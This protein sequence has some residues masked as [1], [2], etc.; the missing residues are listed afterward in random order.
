[1][2][3]WDLGMVSVDDI[4]NVFGQLLQTV[5][6]LPKDRLDL[7][8]EMTENAKYELIDLCARNRMLYEVKRV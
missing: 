1:M 6:H 8:M 7:W 4:K 5:Q 2:D 3:N